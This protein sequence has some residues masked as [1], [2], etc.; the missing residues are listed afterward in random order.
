[1]SQARWALKLASP[2]AVAS[3]R[4]AFDC[5]EAVARLLANRDITPEAGPSYLN[6]TQANLY[7]PNLLLGM[8]EAV[9]RIQQAVARGE[10]ILIYGDYDVDG[11][12]ATV[13]LKTAIERIALPDVPARVTY[14]VPHRLREGY[15]IQSVRL[16]EA[17]ADG[18]LARHL[19]RHRH[20]RLRRC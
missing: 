3:L 15:G 13:L 16:A 7:D 2:E 1:M 20:P 12:T 18:R 17:A 11:T 6:P 9:Q 19:R 10:I 4:L 8:A 14:H 5:P